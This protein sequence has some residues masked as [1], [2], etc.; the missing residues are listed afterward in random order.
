M[1][2]SD[3]GKPYKELDSYLIDY[4]VIQ[5]PKQEVDL[6]TNK[7]NR[8]LNYVQTVKSVQK[9]T[10]EPTK[11]TDNQKD[12]NFIGWGYY[13]KPKDN[14][15]L[16]S[17]DKPI[18]N[19]Y[20]GQKDFDKAFDEVIKTD[21]EAAKWRNFLTEVARRES[22][23]NSTIQN[24]AGAP[25]WGYFQFMQ[26]DDGKYN[27]ISHYA[28]TDINTFLNN[29][30]LQIKSAIKLVNDFNKSINKTDKL[31]AKMKGLDLDSQKGRE[32][33]LHAMWLAGPGGFRKWLQ[34]DN[35]SDKNWSKD[36]KGTS[37]QELINI[38]NT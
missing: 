36:N 25:A 26:S 38:Y 12:K 33:A 14:S 34:G 23:F 13:D 24:K 30:Q 35:P 8:F 37:V 2:L 19:T 4:D 21:S 5:T 27:N 16:D 6:P 3:L 29:P 17:N 10:Q 18:I 22:G 20:S 1:K 28:G 32:A 31:R 15:N 9:P 7:Y 11:E